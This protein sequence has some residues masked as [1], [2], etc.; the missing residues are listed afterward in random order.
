MSENSDKIEVH[1]APNIPGLIFRH[2][3]GD[4]DF[5]KMISVIDKCK[6][7]DQ[8]EQANTVEGITRFYSHLV[9]CDPYADMLLVEVNGDV[10]GY[11]RVWW[12]EEPQAIVYSHFAMLSPEWRGKGIRRAMLH[13]NEHRAREI[14]REHTGTKSRFFQAWTEET[15]IHW[16]SLLLSESYQPAR[17][18]FFMVRS[19]LDPVPDVPLPEGLEIRPVHPEDYWTIWRAADEA[20]QDHWG[21]SSLTDEELKEWME[22]PTFNPGLWQVAWDKITDQVAGVV[23]N[24]VDK[25]E[26]EE[27]HRKRA[28]MGPIGVRRPY[29]RKGL[30]SALIARCCKVLKE[31]GITEAALGVDSENLTGAVSLYENMGFSI[32]KKSITYRKPME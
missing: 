11:T 16:I 10:I 15:E 18:F 1:K 19:L 8:F 27:Y 7:A 4:K 5:P 25:E 24:F 26:N 20:L 3:Q 22:M 31:N 2:F 17:Y 32:V 9:N 23:L 30:A 13:F 14:A 28:Y 29:R 12:M 6:K 21:G